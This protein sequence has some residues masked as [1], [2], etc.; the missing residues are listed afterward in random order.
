MYVMDME[1]PAK[2]KVELSE[3]EIAIAEGAIRKHLGLETAHLRIGLDLAR[4]QLQRGAV[5]EAFRTYIALVLYEPCNADFQIG[6]ANC[7]HHLEQ[8]ELAL[9]A[10]SA[11]IALSP[12]DPRGYYLS[13]RAC[14][15]LAHYREAIEDLKSAI[16]R[17][18][19]L[20]D[21]HM[22]TEAGKLLRVALARQE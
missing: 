13:G 5:D 3:G 9:Q 10:A 12:G 14:F 19:A 7:A 11:V 17:G 18:S 2:R 22:L 15:A 4:S 6:L 1:T 21:H 20:N 16:D 8:H